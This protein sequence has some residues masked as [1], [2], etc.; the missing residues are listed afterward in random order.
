MGRLGQ[1]LETRE[2]I[3]LIAMRANAQ[4]GD[5]NACAMGQND[6]T[7]TIE[8]IN[9]VDARA[10]D[11]VEFDMAVP[12]LLKAAFIAYTIPLITMVGG[13]ALTNYGLKAAGMTGNPDFLSAAA[14]FV[15]L[16]I[17]LV[18]IRKFDGR[19]KNSRKFMAKIDRIT[20]PSNQEVCINVKG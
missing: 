4:C 20:E 13:I 12:S 3:A 8:A 19:M 14:G 15:V 6:E 16:F 17:T 2:G 5:C 7:Q 10:G 9:D 1:V 11:M 18:V